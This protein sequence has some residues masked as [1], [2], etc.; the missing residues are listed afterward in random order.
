MS[1]DKRFLDMFSITIGLLIGLAVV[2]LTL[3]VFIGR[4][5]QTTAQDAAYQEALLERIGPVGRV[6]VTGAVFEEE[7]APVAVSEP[8]VEVL[9]GPQVY[10]AI[11]GS[12]HGT[13]VAGAPKTGDVA[14]WGPRIATGTDALNKRAID[15][16]QGETGY[17]PPKGGRTDLSDEE[18]VAA[19]QYLIEQSQ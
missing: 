3:S 11:C 12:C 10:N 18:I 1:D 4:E 2:L 13:G 5:T 19:V 9:T 6:A 14:A 8:V 15:G 17:M 7:T 16:Y